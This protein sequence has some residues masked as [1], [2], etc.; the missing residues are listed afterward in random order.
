MMR[1]IIFSF[2]VMLSLLIACTES[3]ESQTPSPS[4]SPVPAHAPTPEPVITSP[5]TPATPSPEPVTPSISEEEMA[6]FLWEKLP[7][8]LPDGYT[9]SQF[10]SQTRN[11]TY[12]DNEK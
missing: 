7:N 11:A 3:P 2:I 1:K 12:V 4:P 5:V 10:L 9:K 8:N 6:A